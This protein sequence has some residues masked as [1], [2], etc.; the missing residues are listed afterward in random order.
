MLW[1]KCEDGLLFVS[2]CDASVWF[3]DMDTH[4]LFPPCFEPSV[5]ALDP[6][7]GDN[8]STKSECIAG[9]GEAPVSVQGCLKNCVSFWE[10]TLEAS[11]FV[12]GIIKNGYRLPFIRF[13]PSACMRNHQSSFENMDL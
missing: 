4:S 6:L 1:A 13:L 9:G 12:L 8:Y 2:D 3:V 11:N 10:N 5:M 7:F